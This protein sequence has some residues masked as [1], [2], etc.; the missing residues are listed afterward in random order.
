[1]IRRPPRSTRTATLFPSTTLF[2]SDCEPNDGNTNDAIDDWQDFLV[3]NDVDA[4]AVGFG[5]EPSDPDN[6]YLE[7]IAGDEALYLQEASDLLD[8][9]TGSVSLGESVEGNVLTDGE[10]GRASCRERVCQDG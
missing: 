6:N 10:I 1:M 2:R 3:D 5:F 8:T 7:D 4:Y 9:F